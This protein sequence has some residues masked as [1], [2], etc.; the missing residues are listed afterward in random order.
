MTTDAKAY[1]PIAESG[2]PVVVAQALEDRSLP[3]VAR[4]AMWY[5]HKILDFVEFREVKSA[6]L[7]LLMGVEDQSA[8]RACRILVERGYLDE[9]GKRRPRAYRMPWS[10]RST[11]S[12]APE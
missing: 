11:P 1:P 9:H 5:L 12:R 10:R 7:A 4:L 2:L 3:P 8:G 6:S